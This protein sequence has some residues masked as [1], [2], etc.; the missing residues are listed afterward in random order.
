LIATSIDKTPA[1]NQTPIRAGLSVIEKPLGANARQITRSLFDSQLLE[2]SELRVSLRDFGGA[3]QQTESCVS[4]GH[5]ATIADHG[6][7]KINSRWPGRL[8]LSVPGTKGCDR[9]Q[10]D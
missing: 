5:A 6:L 10:K 8:T 4:F 2:K 7:G 9:G 3:W 1:I